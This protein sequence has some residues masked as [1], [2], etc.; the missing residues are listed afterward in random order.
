MKKWGEFMVQQAL[1]NINAKKV[2]TGTR[3]VVF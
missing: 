1:K 2:C 3:Q